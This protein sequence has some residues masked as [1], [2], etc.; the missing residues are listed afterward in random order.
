MTA[1]VGKLAIPTAIIGAIISFGI[2]ISSMAFATEGRV[3]RCETTLDLLDDMRSDLK[4]I[5]EVQIRMLLEI[6]HLKDTKANEAR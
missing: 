6:Q 2:W 1:Q 4:D 5:K 3:T